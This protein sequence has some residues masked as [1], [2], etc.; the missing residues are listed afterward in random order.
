MNRQASLFNPT[1]CFAHGTTCVRCP[2]RS[3]LH[4]TVLFLLLWQLES[5]TCR[6]ELLTAWG[7]LLSTSGSL[8]TTSLC[9]SAVSLYRTLRLELPM[10]AAPKLL[11]ASLL[12][13]HVLSTH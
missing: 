4:V 7:S 8:R 10:S 13:T 9:N 3:R 6:F 5:S 1:T 12:G 2:Q 11:V